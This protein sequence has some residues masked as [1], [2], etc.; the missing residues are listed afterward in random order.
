MKYRELTANELEAYNVGY[1]NGAR[2]AVIKIIEFESPDE[3]KFYRQGYNA[4]CQDRKRHNVK[5]YDSECNVSNVSNV[6][7]YDSAIAITNNI[8]NVDNKD[9]NKGGVGEKEKGNICSVFVP[10]TEQEVLEY[11]N[12]QNEFVGT[13]GFKCSEKDAKEFFNFYAGQGWVTSGNIPIRDWKRK[14]KGWALKQKHFKNRQELEEEEEL[15]P[16][17]CE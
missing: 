11:A 1:K 5:S 8:V 16:I 15:K 2:L 12:Q 9:S 10:P 3:K 4:G 7:S 6:C 14:L 17:V 13:S